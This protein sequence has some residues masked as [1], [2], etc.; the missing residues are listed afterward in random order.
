MAEDKKKELATNRLLDLLRSQGEPEGPEG[1]EKKQIAIIENKETIQ[2]KL[3]SPEKIKQKPESEKEPELF[4]TGLVENTVDFK[5]IQ[6]KT[7]ILRHLL[8]RLDN[9]KNQVSIFVDDDSIFMMELNEKANKSTIT[10]YKKYTIPYPKD[11]LVVNDLNRLKKQILEELHCKNEKNIFCSYTSS[12]L[13]TQTKSL[14]TSGLKNKELKE[15]VLWTAKKNLSSDIENAVVDWETYHQKKDEKQ[16]ITIGVTDAKGYESDWE[17]FNQNGMSLRYITTIP[18]L[19]WKIYKKNYPDRRDDADIMIH[20]GKKNTIIALVDHSRIYHSREIPM[21]VNDFIEA[22]QRRIVEG[23][24]TTQMDQFTAEKIFED[25]GFPAQKTGL[26]KGHKIRLSKISIHLR[27][28]I[29]KLTRTITQS[30]TYFKKENQDVH[31][32]KLLFTG[33]GASYPNVVK[34]LGEKL[35]IPVHVFN[36]NRTHSFEYDSDAVVEE[37]DFPG[38]VLNHALFLNEG[39]AVNLIPDDRKKDY[40]YHF[41][42]KI[43]YGLSVFLTPIFLLTSGFSYLNTKSLKEELNVKNMKWISASE[44]SDGF[45]EKA[46]QVEIWTAYKKMMERDRTLSKNQIAMMKMLSQSIPND[47]KLTRVE[48]IPIKNDRD[49]SDDHLSQQ[50]LVIG[51]FVESHPSIADIQFTNLLMKLEALRM[52]KKVDS[53]I[54]DTN[55]QENRLFFTIRITY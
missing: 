47:I 51:G 34:T 5:E 49:Q 8:R 6:P 50:K 30:L 52:F 1:K 48:F 24:E 10:N 36:P 26:V 7:S 39:N 27:P 16:T 2:E 40:Q 20:L 13:L 41:R 18:Y 55:G 45:F 32:D 35:D 38:F 44:A 31:W 12:N 19:L 11:D 29:E 28:V 4:D 21:G 17:T 25:Y 46:D 23:D 3:L 54:E 43:I 53:E 9:R 42:S 15:M 14:T 33:I 22:L 37:K